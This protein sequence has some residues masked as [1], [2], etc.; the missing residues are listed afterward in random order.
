MFSKFKVIF[1]YRC[2]EKAP[3]E[4]F[5]SFYDNGDY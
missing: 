4:H 3:V 5:I 1:I 2:E